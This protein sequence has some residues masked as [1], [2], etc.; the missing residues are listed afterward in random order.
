LKKA[1][2]VC[3]QYLGLSVSYCRELYA[4][5]FLFCFLALEG[6][7]KT[8]FLEIYVLAIKKFDQEVIDKN[9]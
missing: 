8:I 7:Q 6:Q 5:T 4:V 1:D 3:N 2:L 9:E